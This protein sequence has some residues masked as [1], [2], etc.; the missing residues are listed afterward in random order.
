MSA[1][2]TTII[3]DDKAK[4]KPRLLPP[5][6]TYERLYS[7]YQFEW[8]QRKKSF[9][10]HVEINDLAYCSDHGVLLGCTSLGQI[11]IW[12]LPNESDRTDPSTEK[13]SFETKPSV[14]VQISTKP[15]YSIQL[16]QTST[17]A[18][19]AGEDGLFHLTSFIELLSSSEA[20]DKAAQ[21]VWK[22]TSIRKIQIYQN[23]IYLLDDQRNTVHRLQISTWQTM[24]SYS[25]DDCH[26]E[27]ENDKERDMTMTTIQ[28]VPTT[29]NSE[30]SPSA[31]LLVGTNR[32][33]VLVWDLKDHKALE[34]V[35]L[36][37]ATTSKNNNMSKQQE[38]RFS[39]ASIAVSANSYWWTIA[40]RT[41]TTTTANNRHRRNDRDSEST[42]AGGFCSTW[43]G[44]TRSL[45]TMAETNESIQ[46]IALSLSQHLYSVANQAMVRVWESSHRLDNKDTAGIW[47][48]PPSGK[49]IVTF[50]YQEQKQRQNHEELVAMAGVGP[51]V[52]VLKQ[53]CLLYSLELK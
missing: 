38:T 42:D 3:F 52:D 6:H 22:D 14:Q 33:K 49:S 36:V 46:D 40:G 25:L 48:S 28:I 4:K 47:T 53:H 44:P 20:A 35:D 7:S 37:Q 26:Q 39:V 9:P 1:A 8:E 31:C 19:V 50:L 27:D 45:L 23:H 2:A 5:P 29:S 21:H 51:K 15:L 12:V 18:F 43:H 41:T 11:A 34:A 13:S 17:D 30:Q 32:S 16:N 24:Y 10:P